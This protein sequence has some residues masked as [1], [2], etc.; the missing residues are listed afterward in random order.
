MNGKLVICGS[1]ASP[2]KVYDLQTGQELRT[3][4]RHTLFVNA[5]AI[6]PDGKWALLLMENW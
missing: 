4:T 1:N 5:V 3:L 6:T 2:I